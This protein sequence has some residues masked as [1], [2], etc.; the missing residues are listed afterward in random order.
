MGF[1][2]GS[3]AGRIGPNTSPRCMMYTVTE[4]SRGGR[5]RDETKMTTADFD[6]DRFYRT[7]ANDSPDAIIYADAGGRIRFWNAACERIFGYTATEAL[8]RSLDI[9]IPERLRASHWNGYAEVMRTGKTR[10]GSGDLLAVQA[11]RNDGQSISVAFGIL[12]IKDD[13]GRVTGVVAT[14]RDVTQTSS[15]ER[16]FYRRVVQVSTNMVV[17]EAV[18]DVDS[19][20]SLT[21]E[22]VEA[23]HAANPEHRV[24]PFSWA[25]ARFSCEASQVHDISDTSRR[26]EAFS[27]NWQ[28]IG[29]FPLPAVHGLMTVRPHGVLTRLTLGW[30]YIPPFGAIGWAFDAVIGHW[31]VRRSIER[32]LRDIATFVEQQTRLQRE[33][34]RLPT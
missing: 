25:Q 32:F 23:F 12:P 5:L 4:P 2:N 3:K 33:R 17:V 19:P 28:G 15:P 8:G 1:M 16:A 31:V 21:I 34:D 26:H 7:L 27:F 30:Q 24:G 22:L 6:L 10:Y 13:N 29:W 18:R 14:L 20:F 9:I 11:I